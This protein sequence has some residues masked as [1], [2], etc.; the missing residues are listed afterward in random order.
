MGFN[1]ELQSRLA[2]H[3]NCIDMNAVGR[4]DLIQ[5]KH[6]CEVVDDNV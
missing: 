5:C 4:V 2:R 1:A 3:N 6:C